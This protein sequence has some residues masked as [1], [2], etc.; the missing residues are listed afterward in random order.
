MGIDFDLGVKK[1]TTLQSNDKVIA[2]SSRKSYRNGIGERLLLPE[3]R[4]TRII[5]ITS[6]KGGVGKTNI[7]ANLGYQLSRAGNRVL[8]L[9]ADL[10]LG[11]LD[12]L[13]GLAPFVTTKYEKLPL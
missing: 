2:L 13:L 3:R 12:I 8:I 9:D 6:G 5:S 7:V 4:P 1:M 11:N 10:G